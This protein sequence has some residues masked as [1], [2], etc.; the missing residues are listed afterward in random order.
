VFGARAKQLLERRRWRDEYRSV[1]SGRETSA[2][3]RE[4]VDPTPLRPCKFHPSWE[5]KRWLDGQP[6]MYEERCP[7][8]LAESK[9]RPRETVEV[10]MPQYAGQ[11]D[12]RL[13]EAWRKHLE[14]NKDAYI[15]RG[16][17]YLVD[18]NLETRALERIDYA[19]DEVL[20][21]KGDTFAKRRLRQAKYW[22]RNI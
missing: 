8:C 21:K 1:S 11:E 14:V 18:R 6:P 22:R 3:V 15:S 7:Y 19:R 4:V 20:A 13:W 12:G 17:C 2:G 16:A 9:P 10:V 5:P